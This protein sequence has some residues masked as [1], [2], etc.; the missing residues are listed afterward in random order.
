MFPKQRSVTVFVF[1]F[2]PVC[3]ACVFFHGQAAA[4]SFGDPTR[5]IPLGH[6]AYDYLDR[7]QERGRLQTLNHALRPYTRGQVLEALK[8][9]DTS[10]L[11]AFES[12]W[13]EILRSECE[14]DL[15]TSLPKDSA[16]MTVITRLEA[17]ESYK[18]IRGD[19]EQNTVGFGFGGKLGR[20]V[21]DARFLRAP[22][23]LGPSD[24][25]MHR[26]PDVQAPY[27]DGLIRPM[28]GYLKADFRLFG[29]AFSS[30]IFFGRLARNWSPA[31]DHSL[32]L[33]ADA[34]SFDHLALTLRSRHFVFSHLV[35]SLDGM[36]Y[37]KPGESEFTRARRYFSAHRLDIRV[38]DNLRFGITETVVYGGEN[39]GFDPALI[40]PVTSFR[41]VGIQNKADHA[42]NTL[43]SLDGLYIAAERLTLFG[44][45]LFD[46][47]LRS[48]LF[49]DRWACD[50]GARWRDLPGFEGT[51]AGLRA[52]FVSSFAYNT[53]RP[54]ERYL[55]YGRPLGAPA[56]NDYRRLAG[57]I[58][59][60][61]NSKLDLK[62]QLAALERG[63]QRVA[64]SMTPFTNST[65]LSFPTPVV[66]RCLEASL[67]LRW[68]PLPLAHISAEGGFLHR[69]NLD[70]RPGQRSRR[71]YLSLTISLYRDMPIIF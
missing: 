18:S 2:C 25:T 49:Q 13:L 69:R 9:E 47:M 20:V 46:D 12:G 58:R 51:T 59:F 42:N 36:S 50:L 14:P 21:Y 45:F 34:A 6:P 24:T 30:E 1:F 57:S 5:Y 63:A 64:G 16:A 43:L 37:R 39:A 4:S 7:L 33:G 35:A 26:D 17:S 40:N 10:K 15:E 44:Q 31:L 3:L 61:L 68:Q 52:T 27:E 32:I 67:S 41:L 62:A 11:K 55:L 60:F 65:G 70:N 28:E 71:G 54:Y 38:R 56:G 29:G 22:H 23:L 19:R 48:D 8:A 53:F 66:E